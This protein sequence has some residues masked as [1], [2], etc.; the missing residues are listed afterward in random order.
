MQQESDFFRL[1]FDDAPL[2]YQ[3]LDSEGR[4]LAVNKAWQAELKYEKHEVLG[5]RFRD[6]VHSD[7]REDFRKRFAQ[8]IEE[9]TIQ[10]IVWQ[11]VRKDASVLRVS[12]SGR[13]VRDVNG[14]FQ[15]SQ[16]MFV[17][18]SKR[19]ESEAQL[20]ESEELRMA[21]MEGANEGF[22]LFDSQLRLIYINQAAVELYG[23]TKSD[24][25]G[26]TM[27]ELAPGIEQTDR[28]VRYRRVLDSGESFSVGEYQG[29]PHSDG[30][31][32]AV[33]A[34]KVSENM[35]L[36]WRDI[37]D[38]KRSEQKLK[39]S[40]ARWRLL[41]E[42][43]SDH[44]LILDQALSIK[45]ANRHV[46]GLA[47]EQLI[48]TPLYLLCAPA[49]QQD[50]IHL[51]L[52]T[53]LE[54]GEHTSFETD[55]VARDG[56]DISC[57]LRVVPR[58]ANGEIEGLIVSARDISEQKQNA[59]RIE[60]SLKRETTMAS[61]A[62]DFGRA[63][64][65]RDVYRT[66]YRQV[67][68]VMAADHFVISRFDAQ[69]KMIHP[70]FIVS[71]GHEV[72]TSI[73]PAVPLAP[74]G[75]G[76]QSQVIRTGEPVIFGDYQ[77][78]MVNSKKKY[79][80]TEGG[81]EM[82]VLD[83]SVNVS[84]LPQSTLLV[85]VKIR[86]EVSG[87]MQVQAYERDVYKL[88]DSE[89]LAGLASITAVTIENRDLIKQSQRSYEGIIQALAKAIE[90]RD[91]YTSQHQVGVARLAT[92][93]A[94]SLKLLDDQIRAIELAAH[95]HDIGKIIIPAEI[96]SKPSQLT[97]A[98]MSIVQSHVT[99]AHEVLEGIVFPWP[100]DEIVAQHHE[101]MDGSGYPSGLQ[102]TSIR[103]EARILGVADIADAMMSHRPY[104]PAYSLEATMS[105]LLRL[106]GNALDE[107]VVDAC[108]M[109]LKQEE[110]QS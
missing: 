19:S 53:V 89:L 74:D 1:L 43:S 57:E 101:R 106:R 92:R 77:A 72:D 12:F 50:R 75:K 78:Q 85:P 22:A 58:V 97:G 46:F 49:D 79:Y 96:L 5:R 70:D 20:R 71:D 48:G 28:Y 11:L 8:F 73:V 98:Q 62:V 29:I 102:G 42:G 63:D 69:A 68:G 30:D 31:W 56:H 17:D 25:L 24:L 23:S 86:D 84:G 104:R 6:F 61:L 14:R 52:Q 47:V 35:G 65:L 16:C 64:T 91:P 32:Y 100:I 37:T 93:I 95:I 55:Y 81:S 60:R 54:S 2:P 15:R 40:E 34:F 21:F 76:I 41:A 80:S 51:L 44:V 3:S 13:V 107:A 109:V 94:R 87:V 90:L 83:Q 66:T 67:R 105:E 9:G 88:E 38:V 18:L 45:Y 99:A 110:T 103:I 82:K 108:L 59:E 7:Q 26:K 36:I 39:E 27:V 4:I 33:H 10:G